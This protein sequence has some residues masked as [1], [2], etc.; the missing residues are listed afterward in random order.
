MVSLSSSINLPPPSPD[1]SGFQQRRRRA[2]KLTNFFG[3]NYR[4]L[5]G[6]VLDSIEMGMRE[7]V[8]AGSLKTD[9]LEV[10]IL[11]FFFFFFFSF[12][13]WGR[14]RFVLLLLFWVADVVFYVF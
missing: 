10:R 8:V 1:P 4:D 14:E 6:D 5:F 7:E 13:L 3:V 11:S 12:F 9:E 2:A